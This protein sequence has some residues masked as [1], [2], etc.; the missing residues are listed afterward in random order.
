MSMK[1]NISK[2][3][4]YYK[5][6]PKRFWVGGIIL[7]LIILGSAMH[8]PA[9]T[10]TVISVT[11]G[12]LKQTILATGQVTSQTDLDLAFS[13]SGLVRT[14]LVS[15]GDKVYAGQMLALLDNASEYAALKSAQARYQKVV[16]GSS[17][18]DV[19]VAQATLTSAKTSLDTTTKT[20]DTLVSNARREYFN[21]DL[22]PQLTSGIS[23]TAPTVTGTYAGDVEGSYV[24]IPH[25][26]GEEGYFTYSGLE[27]GIGTISVTS[28]KPLGTKGL[29]IKFAPDFKN[30]SS[31]IWT[32]MLPN[33][34]SV[35]YL[36]AYNAYQSAQKNRDGA[37]AAASDAVSV[38]LAN[39][40]LKQAPAQS[41]D[42]AVAQADVDAAQAVYAK[43]LLVA[44]ANGTITH[45]DTKVGE[46]VDAQKAVVVLEDVG[47][48]YV[49]A[50]I[51]ET[52]I[53]K[54]VLGQPVVMTLDAF[55]ADVSFTGTVIHIDPSASVTD[56]IAN[57]KI[58][59]SIKDTAGLHV[60]RPGMNANMT[61]TPWSKVGVI[62]VPKAAV[63]IAT[64]GTATVEVVTNEKKNT[65]KIRTVTLG[66]LGDGNLVEI[67]SGLSDGEKIAVKK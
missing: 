34:K 32:V 25:S 28:A 48:L 20:Q 38:A 9:S 30:Y 12:D 49:E 43:T 64:D 56:G 22:T 11:H 39:L 13:A 21:D 3:K 63:T 19:A 23:G 33:T 36:A 35:G 16:A 24:I 31:N 51:N 40:N 41:V 2:I 50:N 37:I 14:L 60:I 65:T 17:N 61:I 6:H 52:S 7:I 47:N 26:T 54:V 58:K 57:Y 46:R 55:G 15:V 44:P 66:K 10:V 8:K 1:E 27:D 42:L 4:T 59:A 45:V 67:T 5:A 62:A 29:Y 18:Q 53:S